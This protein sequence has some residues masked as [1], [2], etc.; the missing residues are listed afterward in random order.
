MY[1]AVFRNRAFLCYFLG[2]SISRLGDILSGFAFLFLA[3]D[4]TKSAWHTTV[5]VIAETAPYLL[6]GLA[7]GV[8]ADWV[9]K[10]KLLI[11]IDL[12]RAPLVGSVF[13]MHQTGHLSYG[14]LLLVGFLVQSLGCFFN[15]AHRAVLPLITTAEERTAANSLLDT[16]A[17]GMQ[18]LS[19]VATVTVMQSAGTAA[20]FAFDGV[21]YLVSALF[22]SL[23]RLRETPR[24]P[25]KARRLTDVYR[26]IREFSLWSLSEGLLRK[27]FLVTFLTVFFNTWVWEVGLLL[28][29]KQLT[30][31][32]EQWYSTL[33]G[34][35]GGTVILTNLLIPLVCKRLSL[36]TYL[37]GAAIWGAGVFCLAWAGHLTL[38]FLAVAV[39]GVG[40]PMA[41]LSRVY[42]LQQA[43]P[44][45]MMGRGFSFNAMLLY[46]A[47][48]LSLGLFGMIAACV[49]LPLLFGFC[50]GMMAMTAAFYLYRLRNV[51]GE[52]P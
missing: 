42:L 27:L 11:A 30:T 31:Q 35:F 2:G 18:V 13:L 6:F 26:S 24:S 3:H 34:T 1:R 22:L 28:A 29:V 40:M 10:R 17:R 44:E 51:P 47:N 39:A 37:L 50:G 5:V 20:F 16:A 33:Q 43:V 48:V 25:A 46:L 49:P 21:T 36:R 32:G 52:T 14:F 41:G 23:M 38:C 4:M 12:L 8:I 9:Q 45:E 19:P 7:G 15:P